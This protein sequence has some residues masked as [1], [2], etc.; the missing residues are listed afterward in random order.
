MKV[1]EITHL[2]GILLN[3]SV[4]VHAHE[5]EREREREREERGLNVTRCFSFYQP[6]KR[7]YTF[8]MKVT[9][10]THL[11]KRILLN[12]SFCVCVC[13]REREREERGSHSRDPFVPK[14]SIP[15]TE[16][17]WRDMNQHLGKHP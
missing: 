1:T 11:R 7:I 15:Q 6:T 3:L 8:H 16:A 2:K 12:R 4:C 17:L 5:R 14:R 9:E 13:V 10:I